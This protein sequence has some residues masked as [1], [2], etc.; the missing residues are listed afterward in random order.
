MRI[1]FFLLI[2]LSAASCAPRIY[3]PQ[4]HYHR[5]AVPAAPAVITVLEEGRDYQGWT[6]T[7]PTCQQQPFPFHLSKK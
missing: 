6:P 3:W 4:G 1:L 5:A 2:L 7:R